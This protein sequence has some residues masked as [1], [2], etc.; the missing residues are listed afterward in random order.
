MIAEG[1]CFA[2]TDRYDALAGFGLAGGAELLAPDAVVVVGAKVDVD[3]IG[4]RD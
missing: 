4:N 2:P 3:L 1:S